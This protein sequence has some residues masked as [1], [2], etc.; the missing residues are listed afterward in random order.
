VSKNNTKLNYEIKK[1]QIVQVN[2]KGKIT[3]E[4]GN[5]LEILWIVLKSQSQKAKNMSLSSLA[6]NQHLQN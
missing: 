3:M 6:N 4:R 2:H 5:I 1:R